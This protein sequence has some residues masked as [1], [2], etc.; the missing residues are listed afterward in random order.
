MKEQQTN[1]FGQHKPR[2]INR[3]TNPKEK[4]SYKN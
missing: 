2:K 3:Q 4:L 1:D